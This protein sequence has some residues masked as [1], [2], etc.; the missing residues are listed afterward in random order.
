MTVTETIPWER[1]AAVR[2]ALPRRKR[3]AAGL[4]EWL[5][6]VIQSQVPVGYEDASGFHYGTGSAVK[7]KAAESRR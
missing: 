6:R 3:P 2:P 4:L 7:S 5:D 1:A